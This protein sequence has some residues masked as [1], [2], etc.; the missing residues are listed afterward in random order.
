MVLE[1]TAAAVFNGLPE[2]AAKVDTKSAFDKI[3]ENWDDDEKSAE[4]DED[5]E[6]E[7]ADF[8]WG[9]NEQLDWVH[10]SGYN[11]DERL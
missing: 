3:L 4:Q 1:G 2:W 10:L 7:Y 6:D 9:S 8:E 11:V 5:E